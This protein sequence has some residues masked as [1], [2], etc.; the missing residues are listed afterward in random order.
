MFNYSDYSYPRLKKRYNVPKGS[1]TAAITATL[2]IETN[3]KR[4]GNQTAEKGIE[5]ELDIEKIVSEF[6]RSLPI[7]PFI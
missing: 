3:K 7:C 6:E 1:I 4:K 2:N 5:K